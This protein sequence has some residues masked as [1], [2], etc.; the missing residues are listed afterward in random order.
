[1]EGNRTL[2]INE[3][4]LN[5]VVSKLKKIQ[6]SSEDKIVSSQITSILDIFEDIT[7]SKEPCLEDLIYKSMLEAK[8]DDP[9]LYFN[10]YMLYRKIQ[11]EKISKDEAKNVFETYMKI[12][13]FDK[14]C[15]NRY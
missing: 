12:R 13:N 2:S 8:K 1:M 6:H 3:E 7:K 4:T 10:L 14:L 5:L 15:S 9:D 11:N